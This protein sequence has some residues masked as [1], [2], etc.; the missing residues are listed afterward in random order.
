[1]TSTV[2]IKAI[3][4]VLFV[5]AILLFTD[6]Y[7]LIPGIDGPMH[8]AGGFVMGMLGLAVSHTASTHSSRRFT[9]LFVVS[10]TALIAVLWEFHEYLLD[11]TLT[12]WMHWPQSQ[13]SLRD[14]MADLLLGLTGGLLACLTFYKSHK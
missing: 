14:T 9:F 10:F 7:Y 2:A 3:F 5:H 11:H 8:F 4:A 13:V 1:M 6:G 12:I